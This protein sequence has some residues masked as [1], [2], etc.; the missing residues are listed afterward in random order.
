MTGV[1]PEPD[2]ACTSVADVMHR[3]LVTCPPGTPLRTVARILAAHRIHA[4]VVADGHAHDAAG[5]WGV[6]SDIDVVARLATASPDETAGSA[7]DLP[8]CVV[9]PDDTVAHAAQLMAEHGIAHLLVAD[10]VSGRPLG[11]IS[12]LD[13]AE[14]LSS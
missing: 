10:R 13:V 7:A 9:A 5:V 14:A 11:V 12:T 6:L 4:V 8:P 1:A 2:L 3:G